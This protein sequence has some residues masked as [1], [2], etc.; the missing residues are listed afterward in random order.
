MS[1]VYL[2]AI[3]VLRLVCTTCL[4]VQP[5]QPL[6]DPQLTPGATLDVTTTDICVPGYTKKIRYVPIAV[7]RQVYRE[8]GAV[9]RP[10]AY[11]IDHLVPLELAGSNSIKNLWSESYSIEWNARIKDELEN[12]LHMLVCHGSVSL[13]EAQRAIATNWIDAYKRYFRTDHPL[14]PAEVRRVTRRSHR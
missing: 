1:K 13:S 2:F 10:G 5:D 4:A 6:P 8:Y 12:R 11:E 7:K 3:F 9:Y 14:S